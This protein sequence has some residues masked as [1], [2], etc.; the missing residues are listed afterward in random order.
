MQPSTG[1][2]WPLGTGY[3]RMTGR[4]K[5][6]DEIP[7]KIGLK[8]VALAALIGSSLILGRVAPAQQQQ[9]A[10]PDA[11]APQP[12][13]PLSGLDGP[14]VPGKGAGDAST[15]QPSSSS[16]AGQSQTSTEPRSEPPIV[17]PADTVQTAP[18]EI[19]P[20]GEGVEKVGSSRVDLQACKL[21][22]S[23]VSPK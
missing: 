10:V 7:V 3:A 18:P 23:I 6:E 12:H 2:F 11:P 4:A 9:P 5:K 22:Y 13:P 17:R 19:P 1:C 21:E 16:E 14:I 20:S 15:Q 8:A